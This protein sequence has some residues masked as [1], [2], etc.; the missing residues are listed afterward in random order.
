[1]HP[2][3]Y[4]KFDGYGK[5]AALHL[6]LIIGIILTIIMLIAFLYARSRD[7]G[8]EHSLSDFFSVKSAFTFITNTLMLYVL[9]LFQFSIIR[10]SHKQGKKNVFIII[11]GSLLLLFILSPFLSA[12]QW[13]L[14]VERIERVPQD[15]YIVLNL[16]KDM[17]LL[18]IAFLFTA[19]MYTWNQ[20]RKVLIENQEL[21]VV[22]LQNRYDAL[23]NQIDPHFLF[24]SLNTL[25]G[26]IG[27]EDDK[28]HEY[29]AQLSSVFRYTMQNKNIMQLV[30]ELKFICS[31]SSML[32]IRYHDGLNI[33]VDIEDKYLEYFILPFGLQVLVENAVKHNVISSKYPLQITIE[34]TDD[35]IIRV[36][37]NIR[38]KPSS[39]TG[40]GIGLANLNERY[41]L[42][43]NKEINI[44]QEDDCFI[45]EIPLIK[46]L[47]K[48]FN[49]IEVT[50]NGKGCNCRR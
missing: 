24:N 22:S 46:K 15:A 35:A 6:S 41:M 42:I 50:S 12:L 39:P 29:L 49:E 18:V 9:F 16:I 37:N 34:T 11:A 48:Q 13:R 44:N 5:K 31:Y 1:M 43:F 47:E 45:V 26:L 17:I 3:S 8:V 32:E 33:K 21:T 30:D 40:G 38:L 4:S 28:A 27:Y 25:N 14:F 36:T 23:K 10:R 2:N 19:L 7:L 20:H